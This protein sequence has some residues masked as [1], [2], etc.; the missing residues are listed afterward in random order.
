MVMTRPL[1]EMTLF[2]NSLTVKRSAMGVPQPM[3]TLRML[4]LYV[5]R[6][7]FY[8]SFWVWGRTL[9]TIRV[10][11][12]SF[13]LSSFLYETDCICSGISLRHSLRQSADLISKWEVPVIFIF[14]PLYQFSILSN[15]SPVSRSKTALRSSQKT[16]QGIVAAP[17]CLAL[18]R[19]RKI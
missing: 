14:W 7:L 13:H 9:H 11:G 6:V 5:S 4:P 10:Y 1:V 16:V 15:I 8:Y 17:S 3:G 2:S 12:T 19:M 18:G